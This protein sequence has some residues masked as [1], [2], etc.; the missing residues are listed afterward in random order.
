[1]ERGPLGASRRLLP[2]LRLRRRK[3]FDADAADDSPLLQLLLLLLRSSPSL[4]PGSLRDHEELATASATLRGKAAVACGG[5]R[6][7][8][9]RARIRGH[10]IS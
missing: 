10:E 4:R 7:A 8:Q 1:M 2:P 9:H 5:A 6:R 3:H